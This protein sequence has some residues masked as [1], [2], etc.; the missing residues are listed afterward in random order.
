M[1]GGPLLS[2]RLSITPSN[3]VV[4]IGENPRW[5]LVPVLAYGKLLPRSACA[6]PPSPSPVTPCPLKF[7]EQSIPQALH[8]SSLSCA[9]AHALASDGEVVVSSSRP[10]SSFISGGHPGIPPDRHFYLRRFHAAFCS[11]LHDSC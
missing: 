5:F 11:C 8:V 4:P 2:T 1:C 3:P 10:R 9:F 6:R 7:T